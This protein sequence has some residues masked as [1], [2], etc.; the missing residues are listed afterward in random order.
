M[1]IL[2]YILGYLAVVGFICLAYTKI[3][4]YL[5][6]SPLH[7]RWELYPVPHEGSEKTS[8]GGSFM[9]EKDWWT[10][11]RHV[12]HWGDLKA[13]LIEVLALHA[14]LEHNPRL[15]IRTYPFHVG[16]YLL[17]GG[18]IIVLLSAIAQL[19]G[20]DPHGGF[21]IFVGNVINAVSLV[22]TLCFIGGGTALVL[23]RMNDEGLRKYT[24]PEH[25]FNLLVFVLFGIL[26]LAAWAVNPSYFELARTFI[27][28]LITF[29]FAAQT[30]TL[31]SLQLLV[32]FFLLIWIPMTHMG[33]LF[34]KYF[35]YHDIRW[36]DEPTNYSDRN[37]QKIADALK[38]NVTWS[39]DHIAGDGKPK[40]WVD[41]ATTNPA[42][43][44]NED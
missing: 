17:M 29:N 1:T 27:Y 28:N 5:A 30:S 22:G 13:L 2:F 35:T 18:T 7:A 8:Y 25:Y 19:C 44:K 11:P 15:W 12:S 43:P 23:R 4:S 20:L 21:M 16:M 38:Y 41:V 14:T 31:F 24:T 33:H 34:M 26:G 9:E 32:G 3:K 36:G 42:A 10:K 39:A 40:T 37:K 6:A